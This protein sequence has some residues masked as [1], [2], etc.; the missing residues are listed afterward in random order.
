MRL[1]A[2]RPRVSA[3]AARRSG[4]ESL[5]V[6]D[7]LVVPEGT[8]RVECVG[9][10]GI[11]VSRVDELAEQSV[12]ESRERLTVTDAAVAREA[13]VVTDAVVASLEAS[14]VGRAEQQARA[15]EERRRVFTPRCHQV[16]GGILEPGPQPAGQAG[17]EA[18][19]GRC[20]AT[21]EGEELPTCAPPHRRV[22]PWVGS[23]Q[24][25]GGDED[26]GRSVPTG[27]DTPL[28]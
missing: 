24:G 22:A 26:H 6:T 16:V 11:D 1:R 13:I 17:V 5:D 27:C 8:Q 18:G 2:W 19:S 28:P 9:Q 10:R 20:V 4:R 21:K 25:S 23:E 3:R 7:V 14:L 15:K 12:D